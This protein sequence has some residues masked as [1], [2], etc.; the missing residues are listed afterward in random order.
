MEHLIDVA[1]SF[2]AL[3]LSS[4]CSLVVVVLVA[5]IVLLTLLNA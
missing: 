2:V 4:L 3:Y 1:A 5:C